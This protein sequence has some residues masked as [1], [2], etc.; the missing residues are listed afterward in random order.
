MNKID[1]IKNENVGERYLAIN[2]TGHIPM[3]EDG[4]YR[5]FGGNHIIFVYICKSKTTIG[6]K[7][8]PTD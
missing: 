1:P 5:V 4:T 7:L 2:P 6:S 3:I 8:L